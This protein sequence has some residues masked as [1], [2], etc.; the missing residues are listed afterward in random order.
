ME[1]KKFIFLIYSLVLQTCCGSQTFFTRV[2]TFPVC[3]QLEATCNTNTVTNAEIVTAT[4]NGK[5]LIYSDGL[6][7]S[8]GFV[9][10]TDPSNPLAKGSISAGGEPTSVSALGDKYVLSC[11]N[12]STNYINVSGKL[13]VIDIASQAIV[14]T[15]ELGGQPDSIKVSNDGKYAVI[16][17]ENE[18]DESINGGDLP[19]NPPGYVV[20][21]DIDI[22][23]DPQMTWKLTTVTVAGLP[24]L[25]VP[26]DPEPEF[27]DI[28]DNNVAAVTVQEN[29]AVVLIDCK[30]KN[31]VRS[32]TAGSTSVSTVDVISNK[33]I[34]NTGTRTALREPDGVAWI[35]TRYFV[36]ADEG[37]WKGGTRTFTIFDSNDGQ[38]VFSSGNE[39][40]LIVTRYGAYPEKRNKKGNEVRLQIFQKY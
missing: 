21:V 34:E 26:S 24:G 13:I 11:V 3:K 2:S 23:Q 31:V 25:D 12:T 10:I 20:V 4:A 22:T 28:N 35:D 38:V 33:L 19:Q 36:T 32:F 18:R 7:N 15:F 14:A 5:T 40:E 9:D 37:D 17:V 27:V 29:N 39:L 6:S 8:I 16:A 1:K 30:S